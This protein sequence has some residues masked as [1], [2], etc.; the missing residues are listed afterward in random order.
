MN[1]WFT[2]NLVGAAGLVVQ[3]GVL[4][5]LVRSF[6]WHYLPATLLAVEAALLHNF[7]WH[8]RWTW[9]D[10]PAGTRQS[11]MARLVRFHLL[12]GAI[13]IVG[14]LALM[15]LL[16]GILHVD[17]LVANLVAIGACSLLNFAASETMVF[18]SSVP[19]AAM[20]LL[21]AVPASAA[22]LAA[23]PAGP[24]AQALAAW[25]S[26]EATLDKRYAATA[27]GPFFVG[28]R[29][30]TARGWRDTAARGGVSMVKIEVPSIPGAKIHHW[31]GSIFVPNVTID[32]V[33]ERL[34][35]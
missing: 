27:E 31:A 16:T 2:F 33:L 12:N 8:Q 26:Y 13:S 5:V 1:R 22:P 34:K 18:R 21:L 7:L 35:R 6:G 19:G 25:R 3:L 32:A 15:T 17:P 30:N 9:R 14:N 28:D 11:T 4:A 24:D 23:D 20:L 29:E 10:R